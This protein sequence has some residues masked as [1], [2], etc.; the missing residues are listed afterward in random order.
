M[1]TLSHP[2]AAPT[3][4]Q[5]Q[6]PQRKKLDLSHLPAPEN[7]SETTVEEITIDGICGVY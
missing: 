7:L 1:E 4:E 3:V 6:P 5:P 2:E